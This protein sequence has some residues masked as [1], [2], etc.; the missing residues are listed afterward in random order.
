MLEELYEQ[1]VRDIAGHIRG[2]GPAAVEAIQSLYLET[3]SD[4]E[5]F[6]RPDRTNGSAVFPERAWAFNRMGSTLGAIMQEL[7]H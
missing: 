5:Q 4:H 2:A 6:S 3:L 7:A 1:S